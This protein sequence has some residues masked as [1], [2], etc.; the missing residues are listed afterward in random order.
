[1]GASADTARYVSEAA[2]V[3]GLPTHIRTLLLEPEREV[4]VQIPI[5]RDN[6]E[7]AVYT[8]YRVQHNKARGPYKG[9]LRYHPE[10]EID[11]VR[12]L[13]AL[14]TWKTAVANIPYGGG[15]GGI[16][17][18]PTTMSERELERLTRAFV[19][20]IHEFVGPT[21]DIPAP[22]VN[23]NAQMMAW[24]M[25]QYS[26][27]HGLSPAVVTG[28]PVEVYG[29]EGREEATGF[30]V[31]VVT[32]RAL[33]LDKKSMK[34][35][36][37]ALQGFGNVGSH[38][39]RIAVEKGAIVTDVADHTGG[40]RN[41]RGLDVPKLTEYVRQKRGVGGFPGGEPTTNPAVLACECDVLIPA[42]LGHVITRDNADAVRAKLIVEGANAPTTPEADAILRKRNI[43]VFPDILANA[44]GVTASYFEWVQNLQRHSW[45]REKVLDETRAILERAFD[46]V[47]GVAREKRLPFRTAAFVVGLGRVAKA[48][49]LRGL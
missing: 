27:L 4:R 19:D 23:T 20:R 12:S 37:L 47:V 2:E 7:V 9:G 5:E 44:G 24:F 38:A 33:G 28:K 29:S 13:A 3:L 11:E 1:M 6:G 48:V 17:C 46:T 26:R 14:M 25:D 18:D 10:V 35:T 39:A 31:I 15:K 30:G 49:A 42:A 32:E 34:G 8:G 21:V 22:D 41:P 45:T 16:C 40:V 43:P 36:R